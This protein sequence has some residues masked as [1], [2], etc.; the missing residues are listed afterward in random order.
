MTAAFSIRLVL[1]SVS[2][3]LSRAG[4]ASA[5]RTALSDLSASGPLFREPIGIASGLAAIRTEVIL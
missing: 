2:L 3:V 4:C 1:I 5:G